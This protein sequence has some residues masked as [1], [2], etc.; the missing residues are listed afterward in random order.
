MRFLLPLLL[1]LASC[2]DTVTYDGPTGTDTF[3]LR[4]AAHA[5][6]AGVDAGNDSANSCATVLY[7]MLLT[8]NLSAKNKAFDTV[9]HIHPQAYG[10]M[11]VME[12]EDTMLI[13]V[14][15]KA[16]DTAAIKT[17][18][19]LELDMRDGRLSDVTMTRK[20]ALPLTFDTAQLNTLKC[21]C[22]YDDEDIPAKGACDLPYTHGRKMIRNTRYTEAPDFGKV[23]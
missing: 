9:I 3:L 5:T 8:S 20:R 22:L 15:S 11:H 19:W 18:A 10:I 23:F 16:Y 21:S 6:R 17:I 2:T 13:W 14:S 12:Q 7:W 4:M 1:F